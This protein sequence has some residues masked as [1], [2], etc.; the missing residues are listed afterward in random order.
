MLQR[1]LIHRSLTI[2][3]VEI[4][5]SGEIRYSRTTDHVLTK[6]EL[7]IE[8]QILSLSYIQEPLYKLGTLLIT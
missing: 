1:M 5:G 3:N 8:R 7:V 2:C 6:S 4:N